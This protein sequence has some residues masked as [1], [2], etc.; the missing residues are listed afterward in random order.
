MP[1][2]EELKPYRD[3]F[4][5]IWVNVVQVHS[6][7]SGV[8]EF[9]SVFNRGFSILATTGIQ[10]Q[11][12]PKRFRL[13]VMY[14]LNQYRLIKESKCFNHD[15]I[16]GERSIFFPD[17]V[18][19]LTVDEYF[20]LIVEFN[21]AIVREIARLRT[22][23]VSPLVIEK[24]VYNACQGV[25]MYFNQSIIEGE[26]KRDLFCINFEN[27]VPGHD[28]TQMTRLVR[29]ID[30]FHKNKVVAKWCER[31]INAKEYLELQS[32]LVSSVYMNGYDDIDGFG[33]MYLAIIRLLSALVYEKLYENTSRDRETETHVLESKLVQLKLPSDFSR[34]MRYVI[35][36]LDYRRSG[37]D[38]VIPLPDNPFAKIDV[39]TLSPMTSINVF[40][41]NVIR[42]IVSKRFMIVPPYW[43]IPRE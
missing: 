18:K 13:F 16:Y 27:G 42:D 10:N 22:Y 14:W 26:Y 12:P 41:L 40:H 2:E 37:N 9:E 6:P 32:N 24:S 17:P 36:E 35:S 30:M 20:Q 7:D 1:T 25:Y 21:T 29:R 28:I 11:V 3:D 33:L 19:R 15:T 34:I 23:H 4:Y 39:Y 5:G 43:K 31:N 38:V 8:D